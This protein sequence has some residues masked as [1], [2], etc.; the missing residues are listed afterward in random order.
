[1]IYFVEVAHL[2]NTHISQV[3]GWKFNK[4]TGISTRGDVIT[5]FPGGIPSQSL[6]DAWT[7]EYEADG[8]PAEYLKIA[9]KISNDLLTPTD[10]YIARKTETSVAV[11]DKVTAY[12]TA[13]RAVYAA[14]KSAIAGA[15]DADALAALYVVAAGA[16]G[17][18][19]LEVDGTDA[20]VVSTSN[21]TV[22]SNGHGYVN[23]ERIIYNNGQN[24]VD[25]PIK[26]LVSGEVYYIIS[27]TTNTFKLSLTP[28]IYG[29]EAVVSLTGVADSG[30]A[31]T[32]TSLGK[33]SVGV[34][35]PDEFNL[36]Y[37]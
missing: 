27:A 8:L 21:N 35:Y 24:S 11:P 5:Q 25:K 20:N 2:F 15:S 30:T 34:D 19:P 7:I 32:F 37:K 31:H 28:T 18:T 9:K 4:I 26:G 1:M 36:A 12:R 23:G 13:V 33:P 16:S 6:Q 3:I 22:T 10:W 17:G 14:V 29:D